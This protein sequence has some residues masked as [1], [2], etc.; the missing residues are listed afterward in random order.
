[1]QIEKIIGLIAIGIPI[2]LLILEH[3]NEMKWNKIYQQIYDALK[4]KYG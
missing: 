3:A 1:M 2:G 4:D